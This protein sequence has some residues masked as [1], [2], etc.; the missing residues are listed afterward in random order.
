M[1]KPQNFQPVEYRQDRTDYWLSVLHDKANKKLAR[2]RSRRRKPTRSKAEVRAWLKTTEGKAW[3]E[4]KIKEKN[5]EKARQRDLADMAEMKKRGLHFDCAEC[6]H[7]I[8][9]HCLLNLPDG[10]MDFYPRRTP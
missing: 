4:R 2:Q 1:E 8:G 6:L 3:L 5:D 7:G 9:R 10:C